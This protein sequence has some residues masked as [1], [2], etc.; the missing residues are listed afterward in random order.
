MHDIA[1]VPNF[2]AL[3]VGAKFIVCRPPLGDEHYGV[4]YFLYEKI[5]SALVKRCLDETIHR[6]D[7]LV[8]DKD[9]IIVV[10][11]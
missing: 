9:V 3:R 4:G 6:G 10:Y 11:T 7:Q 1:S 5:S 8:Q 2:D